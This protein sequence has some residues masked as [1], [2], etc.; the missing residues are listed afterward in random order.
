VLFDG[1]KGL[2]DDFAHTRAQRRL[3]DCQCSL[4]DSTISGQ[5]KG[6]TRGHC[7]P[8]LLFSVCIALPP[9]FKCVRGG[10]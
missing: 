5:S 10:Q 7:V 4:L 9:E 3:H 2:V 1:I 8:H 6:G